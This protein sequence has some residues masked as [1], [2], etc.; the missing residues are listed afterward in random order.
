VRFDA[1]VA[2]AGERPAL[3]AR[4]GEVTLTS[5]DATFE[6][7]AVAGTVRVRV[8]RGSVRAEAGGTDWALGPGAVWT[9]PLEEVAAVSL[10]VSDLGLPPSTLATAGPVPNAARAEATPVPPAAAPAPVAAPDPAAIAEY[11]GI[12]D[13]LDAGASPSTSVADLDGFLARWPRSPLASEASA[14]RVTLRVGSAPAADALREA[15]AW[16]AD[17]PTSPRR[18]DMLELAATL[19]RDQLRDC[20]RALPLYRMLALDA[21]GPAQSRAEAWRGLCAV[22]TDRPLE[23]Q[24]ALGRAVGGEIDAPLR[25]AV[26]D[27]LDRI[28]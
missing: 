2:I 15:E 6:V 26:L 17:H 13:R 14:V 16:I 9:W 5:R 10:P 28:E 4:A 25:E 21:T 19:A 7:V 11:K 3:T 27:A 23:G 24:A 1:S 12:L 20:E 8:D 22:A 18:V